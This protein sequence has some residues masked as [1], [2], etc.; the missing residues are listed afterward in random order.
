MK[1]TSLIL[2]LAAIAAPAAAQ[3]TAPAAVPAPAQCV[4]PLAPPPYVVTALPPRPDTPKCVNPNTHVSTC[5]HAVLQKFNDAVDVYNTAIQDA[6]LASDGDLAQLGTY[7]SQ[8]NTYANCEVKRVNAA[9]RAA[10]GD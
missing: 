3:D 8:A 1:L 7:T 5:P 9:M 6:S 4:A 10:A 2:T